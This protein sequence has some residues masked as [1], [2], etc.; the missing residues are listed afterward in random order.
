MAALFG[1]LADPSRAACSTRSRSRKTELCV[2][3]LALL[4]GLSVSAFSH[5][6]RFLRER[7]VIERRKAGRMAYFRLVN[8]Q[9]RELVLGAAGHLAESAA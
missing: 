6:R 3:D 2:C 1:T 5:Q 4:V 7:A 9:V 8:Q